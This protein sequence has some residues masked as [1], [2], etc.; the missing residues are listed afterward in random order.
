MTTPLPAHRVPAPLAPTAGP[1]SLQGIFDRATAAPT[2]TP[3]ASPTSGPDVQRAVEVD[4]LT[5][6]APVEPTAVTPSPPQP[7][8]APAPVTA[9]AAP[10]APAPAAGPSDLEELARQLYEPLAA[11]LRAE[12]WLDH[13]RAGLITALQ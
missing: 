1:V 3:A 7:A 11:R 12:L 8:T 10:A 2:E 4:E 9:A 13:E 6:A 5:T